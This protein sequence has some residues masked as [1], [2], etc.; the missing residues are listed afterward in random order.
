MQMKE[1][2]VS[3]YRRVFYPE[4]LAVIGASDSILKFGGMLMRTLKYFGYQG[5]L[6]PINPHA[7][8]VQGVKAYPSLDA[9]PGP[10]DFAVI[11]IPAAHV[12]DAV[13]ACVKK[14]VKGA[15][16]FSSGYKE[17]SAEGAA[18]EKELVKVARAGGMRII[19]PNCFGI[20]N[21]TVGITFMPAPDFSRT[22]GPIG[23]FS[24]SGGGA[25]DA[26]YLARGRSVYFSLAVSYGNGADIEGAEMLR[27]F[28]ADPETKIVGA[29]IE[30]VRNGREFF[31]ALKICAAKK[32]VVILKGGLSDQGY[33]G[34]LGHTGS[35]A[36]TKSA[37]QAALKSANAVAARDMRDLIECLMA[38]N[39]LGE[40]SGQSGGVLAGGGMRVVESLDSASDHGFKI[41]E[42]DPETLSKIKKLLP[43]AGGRAGN[44]VDLA[45]P[46]MS[47]VVINPMMQILAEQ[48]YIDFI[49][50][51]QMIFY[52]VNE[53]R[54]IRPADVTACDDN[55]FKIEYHREIAAVAQKI[56]EQTKKPLVM[57]LPDIGGDPEHAEMEQGRMEA[58]L[59]Y[60][61]HQ[62]PCFDTTDQAFSVLRRV[63]DYYLT[64]KRRSSNA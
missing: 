41:P 58:R 19:G 40:F 18:A 60:T 29:Y 42:L 49:M 48:S 53:A 27:Y 52:L 57:I 43:A 9:V 13:K 30:G 39:C 61:A 45:N 17:E 47:H 12:M 7:E 35:M 34:T 56:R 1:I 28:A 10:V 36:G 54:K 32:P 64:K 22:P 62:I 26:G 38:F 59:H 50:L 44:P 16:I 20:Y 11:T 15:E 5:K 46:V 23:F 2:D 63:A 25:C 51:Y 37:W 24:Q 6:Y 4:S 3:D 55:K 21:P 14:G 8:Q 33:R 31:D